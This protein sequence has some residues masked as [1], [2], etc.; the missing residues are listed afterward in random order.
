M[1]LRLLSCLS[2]S[3]TDFLFKELVSAVLTDGEKDINTDSTSLSS[4][5]LIFF[6]FFEAFLSA[7]SG[8]RCLVAA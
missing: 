1:R 3:F 6:Y 8:G 5:L 7:L 4:A 2:F